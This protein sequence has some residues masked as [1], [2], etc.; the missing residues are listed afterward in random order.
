MSNS[1][2]TSL[3]ADWSRKWP[4]DRQ[5]K[6]WIDERMF[7]LS[8]AF[9][10]DRL[11][12]ARVVL[13]TPEFFP[14]AYGGQSAVVDPMLCRVCEFMGVD[15]SR[16]ALQ[17]FSEDN[18]ALP[19]ML[20]STN[21]KSVAGLYCEE[22]G[23]TS[24]W[25]ETT[26]LRDPLTVV[27][28]LAHELGHVLLLGDRRITS[29]AEDHEPLTD[30]LTVFLGLGVINANAVVRETS[31]DR[32][33]SYAWSVSRLGYM[34]MP[35][36]G[37]ALALFAWCRN[38]SKP[39]W[40]SEL[41]ADVRQPFRQ[42]LKSL[43]ATAVAERTFAVIVPDLELVDIPSC[44]PTMVN[45]RNEA[46]ASQT[47]DTDEDSETDVVSEHAEASNARY[48]GGRQVSPILGLDGFYW[49][50]ITCEECHKRLELPLFYADGV[51]D[52]FCGHRFDIPSAKGGEAKREADRVASV[53]LRADGNLNEG[54]TP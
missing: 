53:V 3:D 14:D 35:M 30:L 20:F 29:D 39:P 33:L 36:F 12:N 5:T 38:E 23:Q 43:E 7:W 15:R 21:G 47:I 49:I 37:Y 42:S 44:L 9:G 8:E 22:N 32:G 16:I 48:V 4:V 18:G 34:S 2:A 24:V 41:R 13:P 10:T 31:E 17:F 11:R 52:C 6:T 28:T 50:R 40:A 26:T 51:G 54:G 46:E 45:Q 1:T 19:E 25:I 27:S